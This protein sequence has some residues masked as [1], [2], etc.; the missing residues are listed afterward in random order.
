MAEEKNIARLF[1]FQNFVTFQESDQC[2]IGCA[3]F[4]KLGLS[5]VKPVYPLS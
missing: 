2:T 3:D 5:K 1:T 4:E